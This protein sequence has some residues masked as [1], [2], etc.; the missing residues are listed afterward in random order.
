MTTYFNDQ[1]YKEPNV[2]R[3]KELK[4]CKG[5]NI[6]AIK[7]AGFDTKIKIKP[8]YEDCQNVG[9]SWRKENGT[10]CLD[11]IRIRKRSS[12]LSFQL[13]QTTEGAKGQ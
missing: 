7:K 13:L 9:A 3:K 6:H 8:C 1:S 5:I 11:D 2:K 10:I 12:H 4:P